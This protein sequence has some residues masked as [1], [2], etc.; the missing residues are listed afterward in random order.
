ME[1]DLYWWSRLGLVVPTLLVGCAFIAFLIWT[2]V[3]L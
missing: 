2:L 1:R 3:T